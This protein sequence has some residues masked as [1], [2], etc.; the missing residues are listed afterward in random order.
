MDFVDCDFEDQKNV[1]E[2]HRCDP[3]VAAF[4]KKTFFMTTWVLV[5]S[6]HRETAGSVEGRGISGGLPV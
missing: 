3:V 2:S 1:E 5:G 4:E 6:H